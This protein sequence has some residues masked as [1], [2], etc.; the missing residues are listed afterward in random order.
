MRGI[1]DRRLIKAKLAM[2]NDVNTAKEHATKNEKETEELQTFNSGF[3]MGKNFFDDDDV[4]LSTNIY[5][6]GFKKDKG[7]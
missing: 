6:V 4:C 5:Y 7:N 2:T 3:F 1:F